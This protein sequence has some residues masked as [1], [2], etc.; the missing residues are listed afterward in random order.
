MGW[1]LLVQFRLCLSFIASKSLEH[2]LGKGI[3]AN[4]L[5]NDNLITADFFPKLL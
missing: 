4:H 5:N 2:L 3:E 1:D